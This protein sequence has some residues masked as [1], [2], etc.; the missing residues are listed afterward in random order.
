M[1]G[2][3]RIIIV[4]DDALLRESL[5]TYLRH[6][7]FEVRGVGTCLECYHALA[8]ESFTVAVIDVGLPDQSGHVLA[9][10]I[11]KNLSTG[12]ILMTARDDIDDRVKGYATG[13]DMYFIK[14]VNNRELEAALASLASRVF[15]KAPRKPAAPKAWRLV[16]HSWS[17]VNPAGKSIHLTAKEMGFL[18]C[19]AES[20]GVTVRRDEVLATLGYRIDEYSNRA[21]DSLV[22]RLRKKISEVSGTPSPIKTIH[23]TGFRFLAP[24][25]I[26]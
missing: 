12:V 14:P 16:R 25:T 18:T 24:I 13:A 11:R 10:Y 6:A 1:D 2:K 8:M 19:V 9:E 3:A 15:E 22:R 4:E 21:L 23:S 5:V 17:L 26:I 7:G 20:Y